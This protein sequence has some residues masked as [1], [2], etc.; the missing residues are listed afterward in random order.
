MC[1]HI[2]STLAQ[3]TDHKSLENTVCYHGFLIYLVV[4]VLG[5]QMLSNVTDLSPVALKISRVLRRNVWCNE[6]E[7]LRKIGK[8]ECDTRRRTGMGERGLM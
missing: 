6:W 4:T 2:C 7:I 1:T 8:E 3:D 5:F